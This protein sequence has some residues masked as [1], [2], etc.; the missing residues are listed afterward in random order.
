[1]KLSV[2][3]SISEQYVK[4]VAVKPVGSHPKVCQYAAGIPI[5]G[6]NDD[7]I[8]LAIANF[9]K[10]Y[11]IKQQSSS[12]C[13]PRNIVTVRN[14][15]LPSQNKQEIIQMVDLNV[16]RIVPYRKD[17]IIFGY[18]ILGLDE[19]NY[20]KVILAIAKNDTIRR[21]TKI[22]EKAGLFIERASLSS[23]G[24]WEWT[25]KNCHSDINQAQLYLLLD[26]DSHFTDFIIFS[27]N[28]LSFTQGINIGASGIESADDAAFVKLLGEVKQSLVMFYNEETNKKPSAVFLAGAKV[29]NALSKVI[30]AEL[31]MP[32]KVAPDL[33]AH[34]L[35]PAAGPS[36]NI[37]FAA[38]APSAW[39]SSDKQMY[40]VLPE[41]NIRKALREKTR[42][43]IV[44]GSIG[45][46]IFTLI[47]AIFLGKIYNKQSYLKRLIAHSGSVEKSLGDLIGQK[48]KI[49]V[50][51]KQFSQRRFALAALSQIVKI[52]PQDIALNSII[53]ED[54]TAITV[55]GQ[56]AFLSDVFKFI[57]TLEQDK[58]FKNVQTKYTRKKKVKEKDFTD[59]ELSFFLDEA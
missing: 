22:A 16:A 3:L 5:D 13:L 55:R 25:L 48:G 11:K 34:G 29:K 27:H 4:L 10:K 47:C 23:Y 42:D 45:I 38:L 40:F 18:Q 50:V 56:A 35:K 19:M 43:L 37:S 9:L 12:L 14:L 17:E 15:R 28:N 49:E 20:S 57:N 33:E 44:L 6:F 21:Q 51:R 8:A 32:V 7:Q 24:V 52:M 46:Y 26:I 2:A 39:K 53:I 36:D 31:G 30:E 41:L 1:M 54:G 59:F 58:Y